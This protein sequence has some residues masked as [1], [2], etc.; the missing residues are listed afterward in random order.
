METTDAFAGL[1]CVDCGGTYDAANVSHRCPDCDGFLDPSYDYDAIDLDRETLAERP[2]DSQWRYEELLPFPRESA[3]TT[4]EGATALVDCPDLADELGVGRVLIKDE[5]RNPTGSTTD[6]GQSLTVTAAAQHDAEAVA[7]TST[8][9]DGQ[10]A[11]AYAGRAGLESHVYVPSRSSFSNKAMINV[12]GGDMNVV[13]GRFDDAVGAY[14]EAMGE[15]D[16]WYSLQPFET[17]YRHEGAKTTLYEIVERL[18]WNVPDAIVYPTGL[19]AGIVGAHKAATELLELG[20]IDELPPLYA[21]QAD[22][23]APIVDAIENDREESAPVETPDTICGEIEI[24]DPAAGPLVLEAI[25]ETGGGAVATEDPDVL[26]AGVQVAQ[27]T[28]LEMAPSPAAAASGAWELAERGTFDDDETIV[29]VNTAAGNKEG[30]VLRSHLM[31]Q[32][33]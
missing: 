18:D 7:L 17:P 23:C 32:G 14:E 30:D 9:N 10:A 1:E 27:H 25:R 22:G 28:G 26:E 8:G 11:A 29:I 31:S 15:H 20:L 2:F 16:D 4:D 19:G 24:A 33:I 5:G 12:H 3:V 21:A 6:R 13:G